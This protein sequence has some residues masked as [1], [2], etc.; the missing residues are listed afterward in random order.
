[1][2]ATSLLTAQDAE[3]KNR[4]SLDTQKIPVYFLE[5]IVVTAT[6]SDRPVYRVPYAIDIIEK[7][8]IQKSQI[9]LSLEEALRTV[10]GVVV[11]NRYNLAQGDRIVV[12]GIGSRAPFGVRGLNI[13]LDGIPL[14][15]PDGQAQLNNLDLGSVGRIEVLRG[16]SSSLYGNAGG[17]LISIQ[18][19]FAPT[20]TLQFEPR[21]IMGAY[22]L[23]KWQVKH[24]AN[25][26]RHSYLINLGR[27]LSDGHRQHSSADWTS[28]NAVG[29]H[30][31]SNRFR[32]TTVFNYFR[33]PYL[34]NPSSLTKMDAK[35]SPSKVRFFVKQQAAGKRV[36]QW[37][38]GIT[39]RS[40][41]SP[42]HQFSTTFYG[43]S[44]SL[45]NAIPGRIIELDRISGGFRSDYSRPFEVGIWRFRLTMGADVE[46]QKDL[47]SEF[48]NHGIPE[49]QVDGA[50]ARTLFDFLE[51]GPL[52]LDQN[53]TVYGLGLFSQLEMSLDSRWA[54]TH[55]YRYD[56]YRFSAMDQFLGDGS[57]DSGTRYMDKLSP[58]VGLIYRPS[59][60]VKVYGNYSTAFQTPT[61]NELSNRPTGKGGFNPTLQ[62][63][64]LE[65]YE[66]GIKGSWPV[67]KLNYSASV[68]RMKI[69]D[70]LIPYQ[71]QDPTSEEIFY[72]NA[73]KTENEG[74]EIGIDWIPAEGL[75]TALSYTFM[76]FVFK[77]FLVETSL[78]DTLLRTQ[79]SGNRVP[80]VL[81]HHLFLDAEYQ[82][83][84]GLYSAVELEWIDQF[85]ANDFNG[86]PPGTNDPVQD[87]V[88]DSH[89]VVGIAIG[90]HHQFRQIAFD[91]F[92]RLNN[93]LDDRYN[94]S[95]VPNAFG[96]RFF[97]PAPGRTWYTGVSITFPNGR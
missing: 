42:E 37:Q 72:H 6:R 13:I 93:L 43:L 71:I 8:G 83:E 78:A 95:I 59:D 66:L 84:T 18:T 68:Y 65:S 50:A 17:G 55:G 9:G 48:K 62:P 81:P 12:R 92:L 7:R 94:S 2:G 91:F 11:N 88:N 70:M 76:D 1:M 54:L 67:R 79:L 46:I 57:D 33:S 45:L 19:E 61:T 23:Q 87:F 64:T 74:A 26:G 35:M 49:D 4:D 56:R 20:I 31:V 63:E 39:L 16:P 28:A 53:E 80:G 60:F 40:A 15:M 25:L 41:D 5:P 69:K 27:M 10:P 29:Q 38:G 32:L 89:F 75:R 36:R 82:H 90:F 21:L 3:K 86:P 58:M 51:Y 22:G 96:Y 30:R 24:S 97:E 14:T 77:D 47:R 85:F 52:M 44:R 34:L 73:G